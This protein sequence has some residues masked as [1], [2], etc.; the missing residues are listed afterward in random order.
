M[1]ARFLPGLAALAMV[2]ALA[3]TSANAIEI[4]AFG[5]SIA[6]QSPVTGTASAGTTTISTTNAQVSVTSCLDCGPLIT[7][8]LLTLSAVSTGAAVSVFGFAIQTYSGS[9]SILAGPENILSGTFND[10]VFGSGTSLT[11]SVSNASP[12]S[13][14]TL[15][16]SVLPA[17]FLLNPEAMSLSFASV[18]PT[19]RTTPTGCNGTTGCTLAGF[20]S[21][22]AGTFSAT[23]TPEP[24]TLG[25]LGI[26]LLGIGLVRRRKH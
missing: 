10:A 18:T 11:L 25:L 15:T 26:G 14:L 2:G 17:K 19:V 3:T 6:G 24:A 23:P 20:R 4:V 16:S 8:Q 5:Q 21:S 1:I 9:F 12:G 7:P 13:S 22:V